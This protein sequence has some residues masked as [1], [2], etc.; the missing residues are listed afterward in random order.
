MDP[1]SE[2]TFIQVIKD[3]ITII[4]FEDYEWE[5]IEDTKNNVLNEI[6]MKEIIFNDRVI[7]S[8]TFLVFLIMKKDDIKIIILIIIVILLMPNFC[9]KSQLANTSHI[10]SYK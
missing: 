3:G 2:N 7:L 10:F 4:D 6:N 5:K 8:S 1:L 9:I